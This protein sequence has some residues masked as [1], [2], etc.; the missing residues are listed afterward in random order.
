MTSLKFAETDSKRIIINYFVGLRNSRIGIHHKGHVSD[1]T[2][3][4]RP[5]QVDGR[6][7]P[8]EIAL[9]KKVTHVPGVAKLLDWY[10]KPD[11]F[12]LITERPHPVKDLFDFITSEGSLSED[13]ARDFFEQLV[14]MLIAIHAA[15]V[16]HR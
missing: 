12:I 16:L 1:V 6:V 13:I 3:P 5:P 8:M 9:L 4:P 2:P 10:E 14:T 11:S 15:G 7:V